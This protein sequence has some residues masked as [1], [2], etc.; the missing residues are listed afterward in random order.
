MAVRI[1]IAEDNDTLAE[2]LGTLLRRHGLEASRCANGVDALAEIV[3]DRPDILLLDLKLPGLHG[4]ELLRKLRRSPRTRDLPVVV[5]SGVYRGERYAMAARKLGVRH[6]LEKPFRAHLLLRAVKDMIPRESPDSSPAPP[7]KPTASA[8]IEHPFDR[9]LL[10]AHR[11]RF[12]GILDLRYTDGVRI[13]GFVDGSPVALRPGFTARDFGEHLHRR[14][15]VSAEEYAYFASTGEHRPETFVQLGCLDYPGLFEAELGHL[16]NELVAGFE[17]PPVAAR[18]RATNIPAEFSVPTVNVPRLIYAGYHRQQAAANLEDFL[19]RRG[20][21]FAA[22]GAGFYRY[23]NFLPLN[24]EERYAVARLDGTRTLAA[25]L[26][27]RADLLPL[28][29]AM[30]ALDMLRCADSPVGPVQPGNLPL[31]ALFNAIEEDLEAP[32]EEPLE[33]FADMIEPS[34]ED[35]PPPG[36]APAPAGD[37][38][39]DDQEDLGAR[40]RRMAAE[41]DGKNHYQVFDLTPARFSFDELKRRYFAITREFGPDVLMRLVGEEA[42]MVQDILATVANAYNTLSDVVKKERYDEML[43]SDRIGLGQKG[44]D[45]FQAEVQAQSGK[46]FIEMEEWDNAQQALQ[47]ACNFAPDNGDYLAHLAWVIYRNPKNANSRALQEKARQMVNRSLTLER[48]PHGFAF[49]GWMLLNAGQD[50][51]AEGEFSKALKHDARNALARRGLRT[52]QEKR[53]QEKKGLFRRM[54]S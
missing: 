27:E 4:I 11:D 51:L 45:R 7:A 21:D 28:I 8:P 15:V 22:P 43:G 30:L 14:G 34:G 37:K 19:A 48:T 42:S 24:D 32:A 49:K 29:R 9:H 36:A 39:A 2:A 44:D 12:S 5:I 41:L 18:R 47:D 53:E 33:S 13:L 50:A 23:I 35:E 17:H 3:R 25:V 52:I 40:V 54:F 46:V 10:E 26:E 31:R 6:Y 20:A 38:E 1:L 16:F